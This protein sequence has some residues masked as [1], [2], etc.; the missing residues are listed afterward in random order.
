MRGARR[1]RDSPRLV[2]RVLQ[3]GFLFHPGPLY[4]TAWRDRAAPGDDVL[5]VHGRARPDRIHAPGKSDLHR[6]GRHVGKDLRA[7]E[8]EECFALE[9]TLQAFLPAKS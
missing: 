2:A 6:A 1:R 3:Y 4:G 9:G 5:A 8:T 7:G